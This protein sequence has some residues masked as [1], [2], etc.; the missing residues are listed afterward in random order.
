MLSNERRKQLY[1]FDK[2][3]NIILYHID[4]DEYRMAFKKDIRLT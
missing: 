1:R 4:N 3:E 2:L